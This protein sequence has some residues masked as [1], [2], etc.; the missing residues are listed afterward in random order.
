MQR[1]AGRLGGESME[2]LL[3]ILE[4]LAEDLPGLTAASVAA[5]LGMSQN[6]TCRILAALEGRG[7]V[8]QD[9]Q[10]GYRLGLVMAGLARRLLSRVSIIGHARPVLEDLA[11]K[12]G[13][14]VYLTVLRKDEVIFLD[15]VEG[16]RQGRAPSLVGRSFPSLSTTPGKVIRSLQSQDLVEKLFRG[17]RGNGSDELENL[18]AELEGIRSSGVAFDAGVLEEG[19]SSVAAAVWDYAGKVVCALTVLAP[20]FRMLSG[21][22]EAEIAPSLVAGAELL[23][24]KFGRVKRVEG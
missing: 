9:G 19:V 7:I 15:G 20:T 1:K 16:G 13:E 11:R 17:R 3:A 8:E 22:I 5:S 10:G 12:H 23:S 6:K 2:S 24:M 14:S 21:R 18:V 4:L